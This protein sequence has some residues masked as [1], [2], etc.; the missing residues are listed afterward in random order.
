[1]IE[2][3]IPVTVFA[4]FLQNARSALQK[5]LKGRLTTLGATYVRF[6]Y[7]APFALAYVAGLHLAGN[8]PLPPVNPVFLVYVALGGLSQ[9]VFTAL[10][11]WLFS[12][13]NFAAG[14]TFSK[15]EVVQIAI[16]GFLVLG[17]RLTL[18]G[19]AAILLAAAGVVL[20]SAAQTNVSLATLFTSLGEK[21]T[22]IGLASGAFLGASVVFFRGASLSL[23]H[24]S[25]VMA[26][27]FTLAVAL[28]FQTIVM[29]LYLLWKEPAT[30]RAVIVHWRWSLAV[31]VAGM[32]ASVCWFTAFTLQNAAYVR[33]VGQIEL[34]FTFL[35]S[36][37]FFREKTNG[38]EVLGILLVAAGILMLILTR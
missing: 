20:L 24:D 33:A 31:G 13:R 32:L 11:L 21:S 17:D 16:L 1:M 25:F 12:F 14:T 22:L 26:A 2:L 37:F 19:G 15:T 27:A 18:S 28:L 6:L 5:H 10:L 36:I 34:V 38:K 7:A 3:W 30:C 9:I 23:G 8:E 35:A 4:A 29:G